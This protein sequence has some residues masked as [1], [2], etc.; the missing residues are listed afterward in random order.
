MYKLNISKKNLKFNQNLFIKYFF[1]D[2]RKKLKKEKKKK[3]LNQKIKHLL[4]FKLVAPTKLRARIVRQFLLYYSKRFKININII[5][6][7][8]FN[9]CRPKKKKRKKRQGLR[10]FK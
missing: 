8:I 3:G 9:G 5:E 7:K 4:H 6:K 2:L 1:I 10:L